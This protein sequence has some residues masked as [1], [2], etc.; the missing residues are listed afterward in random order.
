MAIY[1]TTDMNMNNTKINS[2]TGTEITEI[3]EITV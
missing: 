3:T 2:V 1:Q